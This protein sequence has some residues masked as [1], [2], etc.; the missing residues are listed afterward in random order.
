[1]LKDYL[2]ALKKES[3]EANR[4]AAE[5][6]MKRQRALSAVSN[7]E[8]LNLQLEAYLR[9]LTPLQRERLSMGDL[10]RCLRG[11]FRERAH[12]AE[13]GQILRALGYVNLRDWRTSGGG[14]RYWKYPADSP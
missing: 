10:V 2:A 7:V 5:A 8:P 6:E 14:R 11:K 4:R 9:T 1:M 3:A 13:I 12:P